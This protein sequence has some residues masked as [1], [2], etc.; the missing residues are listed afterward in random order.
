MRGSKMLGSIMRGLTLGLL[1]L[2]AGGCVRPVDLAY[3]PTETPAR[4]PYAAIGRVVVEDQRDT[5]AN[6]VGMVMAPDGKALRVLTVSPDAATVV[7]DAF[8]A[9]LAARGALAADGAPARYDVFVTLLDLR[10]EQWAVRQAAVD[11]IVRVRD[12]VTGRAVYTTR[13]T[14][15]LRGDRYVRL[16]DGFFGYAPPLAGVESATLSRAIDRVLDRTGFFVA[17]R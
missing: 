6:K 13:A 16:D 8:R 17:L 11:M 2:C 9:A 4:A 10:G 5:A 7:R 14:A 1:A 15:D 3:A 12:R